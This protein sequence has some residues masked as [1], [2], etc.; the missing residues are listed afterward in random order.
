[1]PAPST[2]D[3]SDPAA[4][5]ARRLVERRAEQDEAERVR[6][7]QRKLARA[8]GQVP[9]AGNGNGRPVYRQRLTR[10]LAEVGDALDRVIAEHQSKHGE[11]K[12]QW[13]DPNSP[14]FIAG[15]T[16]KEIIIMASEITGQSKWRSFNENWSI[17]TNWLHSR[18]AQQTPDEAA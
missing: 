7:Q 11:F 2:D 3:L 1:L 16:N 5:A 4:W 13:L 17:V 18:Q 12:R 10:P 6:H 9:P 15:V 14:R 8:L